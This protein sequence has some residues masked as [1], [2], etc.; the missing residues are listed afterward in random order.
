MSEPSL[1]ARAGCLLIRAYQLTIS[2]LLGDCCRFEPSC[3][4]YAMAALRRHGLA[5]GSALAGWRLLRCNPFCRG[6]YDPVPVAFAFRSGPMTEEPGRE[7][8]DR[9]SGIAVSGPGS[10]A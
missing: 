3:S 9:G 8:G 1:P 10:R 4:H 6:G 5:R 2:P 7:V